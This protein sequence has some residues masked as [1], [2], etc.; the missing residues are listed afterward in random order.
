[1]TRTCPYC[2]KQVSP[3]DKFCGWC[4]RKL[5]TELSE[6][7][8]EKVK[9]I[10][11]EAMEKELKRRKDQ[12]MKKERKA[13]E[14]IRKKAQGEVKEME[15]T[16]TRR[17]KIIERLTQIPKGEIK[18][19]EEFLKTIGEKILKKKSGEKPPP[20]IKME[21][22]IFRPLEAKTPPFEKI[23]IRVLFVFLILS[24]AASV[25]IIGFD[26]FGWRTGPEIVLPPPKSEEEPETEEGPE[27]IVIPASLFLTENRTILE[28]PFLD[29]L[30]SAFADSLKGLNEKTFT[31]IVIKSLEEKKVADLKDF[32]TVMGVTTPP[33]FYRYL[34]PNFT[35]LSYSPQKLHIGF[36]AEI[37]ENQ[38]ENLGKLMLSQK[39][40]EYFWEKE[41]KEDFDPFFAYLGKPKLMSA[42]PF[43]SKSYLGENFRYT[44][45]YRENFGIYYG[46]IKNYFVFTTSEDL[47]SKLIGYRVELTK[48]LKEK[49][50]GV[51]VEILQTWLAR[52]VNIYPPGLVTGYFGPL[53]QEAVVRFQQKYS[54]EILK[55]YGLVE[56]T[57]IVDDV[58]REKLNE[59]YRR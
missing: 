29:R 53:T 13:V 46:L 2:G 52:D 3:E 8:K 43:V 54:D 22:I 32:L 12:E 4:G 59:I 36:I 7:E 35:L 40:E 34:N 10:R 18:K 1:M 47:M 16:K 39:E 17:E 5:S 26:V 21:R 38:K 57:G 49:D 24:V 9:K 33:D 37:E 27:E 11:E 50:W 23:F 41:M 31:R 14:A 42:H 15:K 20:K 55:P 56:G 51:E 6:E 58:T 48:T 28:I 44:T 30:P 45:F 25:L 19:R